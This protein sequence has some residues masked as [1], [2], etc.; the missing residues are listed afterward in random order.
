MT[1]EY[2]PQKVIK[3]SDVLSLEYIPQNIIGRTEVIK[4]ISFRL[5]FFFREF[6]SLPNLLI[7]GG[8]GTGKTLITNNILDEFKEECIKQKKQIKIINIKCSELNTK[9]NILKRIYEEL[10]GKTADRDKADIY[11]EIIKFLS[12]I[13][14]NLFI[15]IDELHL[16]K[17]A[18]FNSILY[19]I[20]RLAEGVNYAKKSNQTTLENKGK[21]RIG[22][23]FISND[24]SIHSKLKPDTRSS[25]TKD[26]IYFNRYE[27]KE[28]T[29]ILKSRINEGA[30]YPTAY[31][32]P[33][34]LKIASL[35]YKENENARYSLMLLKSACILA[36]AK[37]LSKLTSGVIEEANKN[38]K[39]SL[40]TDAI[41][42]LPTSH[43]NILYVIYLLWKQKKEITS[44]GIYEQYKMGT[45]SFGETISLVRISQILTELE[46]KSIIDISYMKKV[47]RIR[48]VFV[49][50][51]MEFIID[52]LKEKGYQIYT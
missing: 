14:Y 43:Q 21:A 4:D 37:Q 41:R 50:D 40:V 32:E 48:K 13:N 49:D 25:L 8:S 36:E 22:Y 6:P 15:I 34:L 24:I 2:L 9:Y 12:I 38:L 30:V 46:C 20:P 16:I 27:P 19:T 35:S 33:L 1:F 42:E 52:F 26:T 28:L 23:I 29:E 39:K 18:D 51:N 5:S 11:D 47:G 10:I 31:D 17:D 3:N 45:R 7:F 44:K